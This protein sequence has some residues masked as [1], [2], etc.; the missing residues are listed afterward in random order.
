MEK[1][2]Q[3]FIF[4]D[5]M[6]AKFQNTPDLLT[7]QIFSFRTRILFQTLSVYMYNTLFTVVY[8]MYTQYKQHKLQF[9]EY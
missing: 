5:F 9:Q 6:P 4:R 7:E 2:I 1:G 3:K 8:F